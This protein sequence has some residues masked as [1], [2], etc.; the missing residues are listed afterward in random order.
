MPQMS[1]PPSDGTMTKNEAFT[2]AQATAYD[3]PWTRREKALMLLWQ[4]S[5]TWLCA[6]TPKPFNSW[7]LLVLKVFGA[8]LY[9]KPFVH[10]KA[11]ITIPWNLTMHDRACLGDGATAY[12]LGPIEIE[13]R[14]TVSQFSYICTGTHDFNSRALPLVTIPIRIG[15]D[16]F[17]G[18]RA[19]I[20]PGVCVGEGAIVGAMSVVTKDVPPWTVVAGNPARMLRPRPKLS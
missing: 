10:Q 1:D 14:A 16:S 9:G 7:R 4:I 18:A 15:Q 5:W 3:S 20:S 12:S 17:V 19:F 8:N 11:V 6:W 13:S 2:H